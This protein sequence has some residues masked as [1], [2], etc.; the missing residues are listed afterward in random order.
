MEGG[1]RRSFEDR[2]PF[3]RSVLLF[4]GGG[5]G[6]AYEATRQGAERPIQVGAYLTMLG[7]NLVLGGRGRN[8]Q[9]GDRS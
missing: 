9:G 7:L 8:G 2:W 3:V 1:H 5:A 6:L 4:L